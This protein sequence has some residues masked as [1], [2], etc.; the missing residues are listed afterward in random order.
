[1][2]LGSH[3]IE[4][5]NGRELFGTGKKMVVLRFLKK[6]IVLQAGG[7]KMNMFINKR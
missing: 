6:H 2:R 7:V 5:H 4:R 3:K 1:M